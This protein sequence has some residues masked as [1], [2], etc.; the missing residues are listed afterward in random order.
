MNRAPLMKCDDKAS[1]A[2]SPR[3]ELFVL[4][5]AEVDQGFI[6]PGI[7]S[8]YRFPSKS[9]KLCLISLFRLHNETINIWTQ[10]IPAFYFT[11]QLITSFNSLDPFLFIYLC[12]T[13][14]F[15]FTSACAHTFSCLS[16]IARHVCFFFDYVGITLYSAGSAVCYYAYSL[17]KELMR[18]SAYVGADVCDVYLFISVFLAIISTHLSCTTRFWITNFYTKTIRLGAFVVLWAYL[19]IPVIWRALHCEHWFPHND[20]STECASM[21]YWMLEFGSAIIAGMLYVS[22]FPEK[23]FPGKFDIFGHSHQIFHVFGASGAFNQYRALKVDFQ[24]RQ[25]ILRQLSHSPSL[26][27]SLLCISIVIFVNLIIFSNFYKKLSRSYGLK[28][29]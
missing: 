17:P 25:E 29:N 28:Q 27:L 24:E 6:E 22:H 3:S 21:Y 11:H 16:P 2:A 26:V 7:L 23:Y 12:T 18:P 13:V 14:L 4:N 1:E 8:G 20:S 9:Y 5:A 19:A 10:L 15:L